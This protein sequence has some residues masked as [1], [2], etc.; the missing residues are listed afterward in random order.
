MN[1]QIYLFAIFT[2]T[3]LSI[4]SGCVNSLEQNK[5]EDEDISQHTIIDF[6]D[7][8]TDEID[9]TPP[10]LTVQAGGE[11]V[12]PVIG[13]Y[14]WSDESTEGMDNSVEANSD[15]P[16]ELVKDTTPLH[17]TDETSYN[18]A[19]DKAPDKVTVKVW[20][21]ETNTVIPDEDLLSVEGEVTYE[22]LAEWP[23]GTVSYAFLVNQE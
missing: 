20:D 19:F 7:N 8:S 23:E 6:S 2:I 4:L 21:N 18:L 13:T 17:L 12:E 9:L 16:P 15:S 3:A 5:D 14:S 1:K 10:I 11:V 22:V